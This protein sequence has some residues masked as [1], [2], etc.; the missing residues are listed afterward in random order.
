MDFIHVTFN[1]RNTVETMKIFECRRKHEQ[2]YFNP[3]EPYKRRK[4]REK[5]VTYSSL[6]S[7]QQGEKINQ[8][9]GQQR[10]CDVLLSLLEG[11]LEAEGLKLLIADAR[12]AWCMCPLF[13]YAR[14]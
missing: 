9:D 12:I 10:R 3:I 7:D 13:L 2:S 8:K 5:K 1:F 6:K 4:T 14:T 11:K